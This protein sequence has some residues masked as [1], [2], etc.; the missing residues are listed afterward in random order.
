M[1]EPDTQHQ[2]AE[3]SPSVGN[4][5]QESPPSLMEELEES[6]N[7]DDYSPNYG[8]EHKS[9]TPMCMMVSHCTANHEDNSF[10]TLRLTNFSGDFFPHFYQWKEEVL[11][12]LKLLDIPTHHQ[13]KY[14]QESLR[15]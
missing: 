2:E 9:T 13:G 14:V 4:M 7:K 3:K 5:P 10:P 8:A 11:R 1:C 15:G 12:S 6:D